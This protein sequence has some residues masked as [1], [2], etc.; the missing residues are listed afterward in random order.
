MAGVTPV[1]GLYQSCRVPATF[2]K[3]SI[4]GFLRLRR[5]GPPVVKT[6]AGCWCS[7]PFG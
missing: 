4:G 7:R 3:A 2:N 5:L 1:F 6:P